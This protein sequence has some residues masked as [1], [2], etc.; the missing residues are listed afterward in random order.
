VTV[1]LFATMLV[2]AY[3]VGAIPFG[4]IVGRLFYAIDV[5]ERGSGNTGTTN[6]FRVLGK[7]AGMAVFFLD[8]AKGFVPALVASLVFDP[9]A[10]VFVAAAPVVGHMY[11]VFLR[12]RGGKGVATGAGVVLALEPFVFL[13]IFGIWLVLV[14]T[15]RIVSVASLTGTVALPMLVLVRDNPLAYEIAAV[16]A[17]VIVVFAHRGNIARLLHG[18][19]HRFTP[20]WGAR[21]AKAGRDTREAS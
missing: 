18:T 19:E 6:V 21:S 2:L 20:P 5:R 14:F 4:L 17:A 11:S 15:V 16:L 3:L 13:I 1:A 8:I 10:A 7:K 12:G 9:W